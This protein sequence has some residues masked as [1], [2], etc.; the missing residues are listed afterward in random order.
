MTSSRAPVVF[1]GT[2]EFA[3]A[4]LKALIDNGCN[5]VAVYTQ[6]DRPARRGQKLQAS[7]VKQLALTHDIPVEQPENFRSPESIETLRAYKPTLMVVAAYGL[8]LPQLV[9][10]IPKHGCV[11]IH[12]SLLPRWRGAAPLQRAIEAGDRTSGVTLM[13]MEAGLD[14][15]PMLATI[16]YDLAKTETA[17]SLHDRLATL[18]AELLVENLPMLLTGEARPVVQENAQATYAHKLTKQEARIDWTRSA[19]V[20]ER[21]IRALHPSP[22]AWCCDGD[23]R[24]RVLGAEI[25]G[26]GGLGSL[27][28]PAGAQPGTVIGF[29]GHAIIVL[30]REKSLLGLTKIQLAG[31]KPVSAKDFMNSQKPFLREGTVLETPA[32]D[33][34]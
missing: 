20:I 26:E 34:A 24:I 8:L 11:N 31:A 13:Q 22:M 9:L 3:A 17:D 2:P 14:T 16:Q 28:I 12:A 23:E 6:P 25:I 29:N 4:S 10:D 21:K 32:A 30:C 33:A 18:G 15:G 19:T 1:A 27:T 5:V 7:A